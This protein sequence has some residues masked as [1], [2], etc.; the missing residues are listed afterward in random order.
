M[1][2]NLEIHI[3]ID[4]QTCLEREWARLPLFSFYRPKHADPESN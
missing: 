3:P 4:Y 1:D 2:L